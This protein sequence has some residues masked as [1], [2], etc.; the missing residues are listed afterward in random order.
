M[1]W[2]MKFSWQWRW[3]YS[4][5]GLWHHV[6]TPIDTNV[7]EKQ[8][9]SIFTEHEDSMFTHNVIYLQVHTASQLRRTTSLLKSK[10]FSTYV[11]I[12]KNYKH[13]NLVSDAPCNA[14]RPV[15]NNTFSVMTEQ[16]H[17]EE[18]HAVS[19]WWKCSTTI[20]RMM[21]LLHPILLLRK[22]NWYM[23]YQK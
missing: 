10:I 22:L 18:S 16:F 15:Y 11:C 4:S 17:H 20:F 3:W 14:S 1:M 6:N 8:T 9:V 12:I 5:S 21:Y 7:S 13:I 19:Y 23:Q 2:S